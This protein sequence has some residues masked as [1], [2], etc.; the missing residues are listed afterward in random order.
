MSMKRNE[1]LMASCRS[2]GPEVTL[3]TF[4]LSPPRQKPLFMDTVF[5]FYRKILLKYSKTMYSVNVLH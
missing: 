5:I 2:A 3:K 4:S 1:Y